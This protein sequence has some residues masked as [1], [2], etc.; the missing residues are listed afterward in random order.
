MPAADQ[1]P[2]GRGAAQRGQSVG[3]AAGLRGG[4]RSAI[5][6]SSES[7]AA[8]PRAGRSVPL[9]DLRGRAFLT[10][11]VLSRPGT[12]DA[13]RL[14]SRAGGNMLTLV[15][16]ATGFIGGRIAQVLSA[17]GD[18]VRGLV[19]DPGRAGSAYIT[20]RQLSVTGQTP[21]TRVE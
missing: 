10:G 11:R 3:T 16:G 19:R 4:P 15:T 21:T 7:S 12:R 5:R 1:C 18:E 2:V 17:R 20:P 9:G 8:G 6:Q 14:G 13:H